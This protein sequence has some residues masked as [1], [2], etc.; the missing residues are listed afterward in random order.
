M[1]LTSRDGSASMTVV[2]LAVYEDGVRHDG[3]LKLE[4]TYAICRQRGAFA[5]IGLYEPTEEEFDSV[6]REFQLHEL[7]VEDAIHA[8]QRPKLE[9]Y[10]GMIFIVL[11]TARYIDETETVEFGEILM[12]VGDDFVI[13]VRHG[14]ASALGGVRREVEA[15]PD[16]L[17]C[18][19][20]AVLHAI[21]DRV[22]DDYE[23]VIA[24]IEDDIEEVEDAVFSTER[25]NPAE[26][27]YKLKR[28]VIE[29]HRAVAPLVGPLDRLAGGHYEIHVEIRDYFRDVYD[30]AVRD[31]E[32]ID[33]FQ[34][35]LKS[36]L[37]A[38]LAQQTVRQNADM[39]RITAWVAILAVPTAMA[40][41]Y[42]MNFKHMPELEWE[43]GYP[44]AL[45]AM[46]AI[47]AAVYRGFKK[48][49]WL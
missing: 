38:N 36:A 27:I 3:K 39:R 46:V 14:E 48:A 26:R 33:E 31:L 10:E 28:E 11:K 35:L 37:E 34:E 18:G 2:D 49:G 32:R 5:W 8:H 25:S 44:L 22:V 1:E 15:R 42:G 6:A 30:H 20:G 12:F 17:R 9:L 23:P 7:A 21:V 24:G 16:L 29:F 13:T 47:C 43:L 4:E 19:P 45:A 40:G 41:I